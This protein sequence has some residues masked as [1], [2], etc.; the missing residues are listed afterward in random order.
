MSRSGPR[1]RHRVLER[2]DLAIRLCGEFLGLAFAQEAHEL[3]VG[4]AHI[5]CRLAEQLEPGGMV[6]DVA[7]V[8]LGA[9]GLEFGD[10]LEEL[11][12]RWIRENAIARV[13][14]L[15]RPA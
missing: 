1:I 6:I 3:A 8:E 13:P 5:E 11:P 9:G 15:F 4:L 2:E 12:H 7:R 14:D 10:R